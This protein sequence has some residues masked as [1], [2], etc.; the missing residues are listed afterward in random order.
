MIDSKRSENDRA[1]LYGADYSVYTRIARLVLDEVGMS[2]DFT[3][4]DIFESDSLP[5][6][7][8][9]RHPFLKIPAFEHGG[10]SLY[11]TDAIARY[12]IALQGGCKLL[13]SD[14][15]QVA[16][17]AQ[18]M[19]IVD[20]YAYP[21]LVWGVFVPEKEGESGEPVKQEALR[22]ARLVLS[23]LE[24]LAA[25]PFL[26]GEDFS[27]ADIW[28]APVLTYFQLA[29]TGLEMMG[30]APRLQAWLS[31]MH[32]RP[33]MQTTRYPAEATSA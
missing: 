25:A 19:R 10:F 30:D 3:E 17:A 23:A 12:V 21:R 5:P 31:R 1:V 28:A 32:E 8:R 18:I 16:R 6:D 14:A 7:Y 22:E 27:L 20:N 26:L 15:R 4:L 29:P 13:P 2:Y 24:D 11:E 9:R 33:S